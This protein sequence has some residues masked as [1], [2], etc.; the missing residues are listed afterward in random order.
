MN[1]GFCVGGIAFG[2]IYCAFV[3]NGVFQKTFEL[4][5]IGY[6]VV[7]AIFQDLIDWFL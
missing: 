5:V 4:Y 3:A 7:S 1:Y 2:G 6:K